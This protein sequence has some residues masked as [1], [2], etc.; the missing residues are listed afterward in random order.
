MQLTNW[1]KWPLFSEK[2]ALYWVKSRLLTNWWKCPK[3]SAKSTRSGK[4]LDSLQIGEYALIFLQNQ[5]CIGKFLTAYKLV[6]SAPNFLQPIRLGHNRN[7]RSRPAFGRPR[8]IQ[9]EDKYLKMGHP[10]SV[11]FCWYSIKQTSIYL[12]M[13][14]NILPSP[15]VW[16]F[17]L[18][19]LST[20]KL[21]KGKFY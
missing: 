9:W 14:K 16:I 1:W 3:F 18:V 7:L 10:F 2:S 11:L 5:L 17:R 20:L 21:H 6:K 15:W 19:D 13:N 8:T 4:N 12:S